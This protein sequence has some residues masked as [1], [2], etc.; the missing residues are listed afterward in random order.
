[1]A[2]RRIAIRQNCPWCTDELRN[3]KR[4]R[5]QLERKLQKKKITVDQQIYRNQYVMVNKI[6]LRNKWK[7]YSNTV[8]E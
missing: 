6:Q 4:K 1:M 8:I 7:Y 3:A 2:N 5:R